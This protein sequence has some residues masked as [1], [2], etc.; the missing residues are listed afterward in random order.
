MPGRVYKPKYT[1]NGNETN[2]NRWSFLSDPNGRLNQ[3]YIE[4][5]KS[6]RRKRVKQPNNKTISQRFND[7]LKSFNITCD[8]PETFNSEIPD[9][10]YN[11]N[12]TLENRPTKEEEK[13]LCRKEI[14]S[15]AKIKT[16]VQHPAMTY[17]DPKIN[18]DKYIFD[19]IDEVITKY[20]RSIWNIQNDK[21]DKGLELSDLK[22]YQRESDPNKSSD[23][24]NSSDSD[25]S[26]TTAS[27]G[28][29]GRYN[30]NKSKGKKQYPLKKHKFT[31]NYKQR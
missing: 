15:L 30:K 21:G 12:Y 26:F 20:D 16:F 7:T 31:V 18:Q 3:L 6:R 13:N 24:K 27:E 2:I 4:L 10:F 1:V 5:T 11:Y 19:P 17:R 14:N 9:D 28:R 22:L 25:F 29:G 23:S 8:L